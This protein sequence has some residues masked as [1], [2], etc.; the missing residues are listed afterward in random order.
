LAQGAAVAPWL[1]EAI[2]CERVL[3]EGKPQMKI[4]ARLAAINEERVGE[5]SERD[6]FWSQARRKLGKLRRLN[7]REI[8]Q[9]RLGCRVKEGA[10]P[11]ASLSR[12]AIAS[13]S[14]TR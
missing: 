4:V 6:Y 12:A 2:L 11:L 14:F 1:I 5:I 9:T 10:L 8:W 7:D 13:R 3:L